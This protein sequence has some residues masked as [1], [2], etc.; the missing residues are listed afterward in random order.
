M[1][2][3]TSARLRARPIEWAFAAT[4]MKSVK[5]LLAA[6]QQWLS[7]LSMPHGW[8]SHWHPNLAFAVPLFALGFVTPLLPPSLTA[9]LLL[10]AGAALAIVTAREARA[11]LPAP[12]VQRRTA[13]EAPGAIAQRSSVA[14]A[15]Q[16]SE[17]AL[18]RPAPNLTAV[19]SS[20]RR[21]PRITR[22]PRDRNWAELMARVNHDLRTPLNAVIGFS[23]LMVL[24]LFGPLGDERYQDYAQH[25]R[26]SATDLLKSAED[27]LALTALTANPN[28]REGAVACDL[29]QLTADAWAFVCRKAAARDITFAPY[30]SPGLEVLGEHRTLRQILV[31]M[32]SE[33][34]GR[35]AYGER[36]MLMADIEGELIELTVSVSKERAAPGREEGSLAICLART[37]LEMQGTSLLEVDSTNNGWRAVTVLDRAVQT[38]FFKDRFGVPARESM[39]AFV[40]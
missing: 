14:G 7:R 36:V 12:V 9:L 10:S 28:R 21:P 25:I 8:M 17:I 40:S 33:A 29:E 34:V 2:W 3:T 15:F 20:S 26:D 16:S 24:E 6:G 19:R 22:D 37:L 4:R 18:E 5:Y 30:F 39:A 1:A 23:E 27:T 11:P 31:N 38:D 32:L 13:T 35:A